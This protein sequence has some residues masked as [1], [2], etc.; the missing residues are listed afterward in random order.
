MGVQLLDLGT[1]TENT[2]P[3]LIQYGDIVDTTSSSSPL[4]YYLGALMVNKQGDLI[5]SFNVSGDDAYVNAGYAF[6]AASGPIDTPLVPVLVTD[7]SFPFNWNAN[8]S[9][10]PGPAIQ[11]WGDQ[12]SVVTDP[13]DDLTFWINQPFA[14][15]Q[16]AWGVQ[17]VQVLPAE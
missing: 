13:G 4:F 5:I 14:A 16:N 2:I 12:S 1:E 9:L 10:N 17:A 7:T 6:R 11:R 3:V 15:V 8:L